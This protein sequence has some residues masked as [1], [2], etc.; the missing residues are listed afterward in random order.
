M[1]NICISIK[2]DN[3]KEVDNQ[4]DNSKY[5][6]I[7]MTRLHIYANLYFSES[8]NKYYT[9]NTLYIFAYLT[10]SVFFYRSINA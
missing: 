10:N 3:S 4:T 6:T 1:Q 5:I 9:L 7:C 8:C 2:L